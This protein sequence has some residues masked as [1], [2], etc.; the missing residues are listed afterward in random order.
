MKKD[1]INKNKEAKKPL[2]KKAKK[3]YVLKVDYGSDPKGNCRHPKDSKIKLT[4]AEA[5]IFSN[6]KYI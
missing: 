5:K 2:Y 4:L 3:S 1:K 6:L